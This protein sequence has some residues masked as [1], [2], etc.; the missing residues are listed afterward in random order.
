MAGAQTFRLEPPRLRTTDDPGEQRHTTWFE[1]YFDLVFVGALAELA[2]GLAKDPS[3]AVF[4]RFAGLFV[5]VSWAWTGF[6]MYA[7]RFDTDDVIYRLSKSAA[8]LAVAALAIQIPG[9]IS[10]DGGTAGFAAAYVV[11]RL[12]LIAMY[13]RARR[14]VHDQGRRLIDIYISAFLLTTGL[15][16]VSIAVPGP[17]R[18]MLW[19]LALAIDLTT[20]PRA[21]RTLRAA[22]VVVSHV[23]DR[24][25]T[26]FIIVLGESVVADAVRVST[27]AGRLVLAALLLGLAAFGGGITPVAF[28]VIVCSAVVGQLLLEAFTFPVGAATIWEPPEVAEEGAG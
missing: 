2:T 16:L 4:A 19:G 21:W 6:T 28:I 20:P 12:I 8:A 14:H 5:V 25:G 15:W 24:F 7:N 9:V 10:G 27:F 1:L 22:P 17:Y 11:V 26:F 13:I 3:P 18:Y 23:T